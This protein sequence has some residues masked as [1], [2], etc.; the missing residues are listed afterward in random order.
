MDESACVSRSIGL[1]LLNELDVPSLSDFT[2]QCVN[3]RQNMSGFGIT[4]RSVATGPNPSALSSRIMTKVFLFSG[5][6][7]YNSGICR[8]LIVI[9]IASKLQRSSTCHPLN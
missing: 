2:T 4:R 5:L 7:A 9:C 8:G 6:A 3:H 1:S